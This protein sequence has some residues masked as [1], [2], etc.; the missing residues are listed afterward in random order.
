MLQGKIN[1]ILLTL[2]P[3]WLA[4]G[5]LGAA[6]S[7]AA[8]NE[9][10]VE[11][12]P[13][14][15][16][17]SKAKD[18]SAAVGYAVDSTEQMGPWGELPLQDTPY[19]VTVVPSEL[20]ENTGTQNYSQ[21]LSRIPQVQSM[22]RQDIGGYQNFLPMIRGLGA[23][24]LIDG[25]PTNKSGS[26]AHMSDI[27]GDP[28]G[29]L[30]EFERVEAISGFSGFLNG[31]AMAGGAGDGIAGGSIN[32][33]L[34]RP[35]KEFYN[36]FTIGNYG[37]EQF[38]LKGDLGGPIMDGKFGYRVNFWGS[39]GNTVYE[40]MRARSKGASLAFDWNIT[41][42]LL[43]QVDYT[44]K[45]LHHSGNKGG[46]DGFN[47]N[48]AGDLSHI[49]DFGIPNDV[50]W[51]QKWSYSDSD[52]ER[53][54]ANLTWKLFDDNI[55]VRAAYKRQITKTEWD[56]GFTN[57]HYNTKVAGNIME[58]IMKHEWDIDGGHLF[59][60]SKFNT[61]ILEHKLT[62]GYQAT[63]EKFSQPIP[64]SLFYYDFSPTWDDPWVEQPDHSLPQRWPSLGLHHFTGDW[65]VRQ[66][67]SHKD[68]IIGD[69]IKIGE[70]F[71]ALLGANFTT[72][73]QKAYKDQGAA[74][75][76]ADIGSPEINS[77]TGLPQFYKKSAWTPNYSLI[78]KPIEN[79]SIYGTYIEALRRGGFVG[80]TASL[81]DPA[82]IY[83]QDLPS[84]N[85]GE[86]LEPQISKQ[87]E[88]GVNSLINDSLR[89]NLAI[90][91]IIK[92]NQLT[93]YHEP[94]PQYPNGS[95]STAIDGK[96]IHKGIE[97]TVTGKIFDRL[98]AVGG[99]TYLKAKVKNLADTPAN[100]LLEG[101]PKTGIP[102]W[103]AK[104]YLEYELP[105]IDRFYLV[106]AAYYLGKKHNGNMATN[107]WFTPSF[108]FF[109]AGLR[110]ETQ[111]KGVDTTFNLYASNVTNKYY[112]DG[113][114]GDPRTVTFSISFEF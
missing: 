64:T 35:T 11:L 74:S 14:H 63:F 83:H 100:K 18:G 4:F 65:F 6:K 94:D 69:Q 27:Y 8:D 111:I 114:L 98:T 77:V 24:L 29:S 112:W 47:R 33:I 51:G 95:A 110:F 17:D 80:A 70:K 86:T 26:Q 3:L 12:N 55:I 93:T 92:A 109:D 90:F 108:T 61:S 15:V 7:L 56:I 45:L 58:G 88:L 43:F 103:T 49:E 87:Y 84:R 5:P 89:L 10:T 85:A 20:I 40:G 105:F 36:R 28:I 76:I 68:F 113:G 38:Y 9:E 75:S 67:T 101:R 73:S 54:G 82:G 46:I 78:F 22:G 72:I 99:I 16:S 106:G 104:L 59:I 81:T 66:R 53:Y 32:F 62:V 2:I 1:L 102:D 42:D 52:I 31:G 91:R 79:I 107:D 34:K 97:L 39:D 71:I 23:S 19:S 21:V 30:E 48:T 25:M 96:D 57:F 41:N 60:D 50:A 37:G 44:K 13:L